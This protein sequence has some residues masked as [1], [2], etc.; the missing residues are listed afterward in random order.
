MI[1][2]MEE[3]WGGHCHWPKFQL[4]NDQNMYPHIT[5]TKHFSFFITFLHKAMISN[6]G[7]DEGNSEGL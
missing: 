3:L 2:V 4:Q 7:S 1:V 6:T 5:H